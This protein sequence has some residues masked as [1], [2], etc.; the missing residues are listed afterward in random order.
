M[1]RLS[2]TAQALQAA[3]PARQKSLA[4]SL[5]PLPAG[6]VLSLEI[7]HVDTL[8]Q[9]AT[10]RGTA[11]TL[12]DWVSNVLTWSRASDLMGVGQDE[13]TF[14]LRLC[15]DLIERW[16]R[17]GRVAF[18]GPGYQL[19]KHG[20]DVMDALARQAPVCVAREAALWSE[21]QLAR[22]RAENDERTAA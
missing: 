22:M 2:P 6:D 13:M 3:F 5:Q 9:I 20:V 16:K 17:T 12:W 4:D 11:Q 15:M 14:Q 7:A 19:A 10:G 21:E 8:D 1:L 18:D